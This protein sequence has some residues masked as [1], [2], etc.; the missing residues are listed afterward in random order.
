VA[1]CNVLT[2][3]VDA[4]VDLRHEVV[5]ELRSPDVPPAL[6]VALLQELKQLCQAIAA[7][8]LRPSAFELI[9]G[10]DQRQREPV[11][12]DAYVQITWRRC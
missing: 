6:R 5:Q 7:A 8:R 3:Q 11:A 9:V 10:S 2:R 4:L 1:P 12:S